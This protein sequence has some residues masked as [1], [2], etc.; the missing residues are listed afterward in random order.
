MNYSREA[1][2]PN[3]KDLN[4]AHMN[5]IIEKRP[6]LSLFA[7]SRGLGWVLGVIIFPNR[8]TTHK[9]GESKLSQVKRSAEKKVDNGGR[10][11]KPIG[12]SIAKIT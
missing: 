11:H 5:R 12:R 4:C 8:W 3:Q 10:R 9:K 1:A 2:P 6:L 7:V